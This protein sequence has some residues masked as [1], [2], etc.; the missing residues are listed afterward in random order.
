MLQILEYNLFQQRPCVSL[1]LYFH[2]YGPVLIIQHGQF[3][4][5]FY[6]PKFK[7]CVAL[8]CSERVVVIPVIG[9]LD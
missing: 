7:A 4:N 5:T 2:K 3:H 8:K 9:H 1:I 6:I